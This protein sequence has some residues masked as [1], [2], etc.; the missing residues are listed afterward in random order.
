MKTTIAMLLIWLAGCVP[1]PATEGYATYYTE[2]SCKR[3]GTSGTLTASGA[4]YDES[5]MTCALPKATAKAW[6]IKYGASV[7]VTSL[8]TGRTVIVRYTDR[9]PGRLAR[10]RKVTVDL[11]PAA[12]IALAGEAGI[13]SGRVKVKIERIEK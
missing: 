8:T 11:T 12:M 4:R 5:K 2:Q 10:S 3:E 7:R 6:N 13:K 1:I 9:G